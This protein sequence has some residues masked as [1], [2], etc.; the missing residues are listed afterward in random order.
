[1]NKLTQEQWI[2]K[3]NKIHN[4]KYDYSKLKYTHNKN[5]VSITCKKH[6]IFQQLARNHILGSGCKECMKDSLSDKFALSKEEFINK[7]NKLHN[8]KYDYSKVKYKNYNSIICIICPEHEEF[9]QEASNHLC[10]NGCPACNESKGEVKIRL[11]LNKYKF[12]YTVQEWFKNSNIQCKNPQT[13]TKMPFD[14]YL[15]DCNTCIEYDGE[16]HYKP[17]SFGADKSI[18]TKEKNLKIMQ[19][20][21]SIKTLYCLENKIKLIRIPYVMFNNIDIILMK[22]LLNEK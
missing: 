4:Y 11:F 17:H 12:N 8:N 18:E 5:K 16:Q 21:D 1:M 7:S 20:R 19:Y 22:E 14:F 2:D 15:P 9:W 10:G 6:G 13:N 3:A